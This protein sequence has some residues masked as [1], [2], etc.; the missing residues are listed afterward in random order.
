M[1]GAGPPVCQAKFAARETRSVP[2]ARLVRNLEASRGEQVGPTDKAMI[3]FRIGRLHA[4]AYALKTEQGETEAC[5]TPG[6]RYELPDFG[7]TPDHAQFEVRPTRDQKKLQSAIAHLRQAIKH[8]QT[9]VAT[10][11]TF[12]PARLGLA[13]CLDQSGDKRRALDM[14]RAILK[15][16]YESERQSKGGMYN[17]SVTVETSGYLKQLLDKT[18][19]AKE[20]AELNGKISELEKLPRFVTPILIPLSHDTDLRRLLETPP[21]AVKFDLDGFGKK[22]YGKW[23]GRAAGW[24]VFDGEGNGVVSSGLQMFGG[25]TFWLF[26]RNGYQAL[27]ALDDDR[28][29]VV[30]GEETAH[31]SVWQD[32]DLDGVSDP[33]E[34]KPL[35]SWGI[36]ALNTRYDRSL[37]HALVSSKGARLRRGNWIPT[38]DVWLE[39]G[40]AAPDTRPEKAPPP[41][42]LPAL[43]L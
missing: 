26:W 23:P 32:I 38:Y 22:T 9:A 21:R 42:T 15:D 3:D 25:S 27:A 28:D 41:P 10:N 16:A 8:L 19:D 35:A 30:A 17:W 14:Y 36:V 40:P 43:A 11:P 2:I 29:G 33:G 13:W 39:S 18:R 34:V 24:L 5:V 7:F 20:I 4:M 1:A 37:N 31:L 6:S 12:L